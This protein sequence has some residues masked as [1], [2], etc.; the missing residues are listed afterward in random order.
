MVDGGLPGD[1]VGIPNS[2]KHSMMRK[3]R[4][5]S[6]GIFFVMV[7]RSQ[8]VY[9]EGLAATWDDNARSDPAPPSTLTTIYA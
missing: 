1:M 2:I 8:Q 6:W 9:F 7:Q 4:R 5:D 3:Q